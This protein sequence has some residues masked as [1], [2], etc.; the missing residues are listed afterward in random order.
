MPSNRPLL[1]AAALLTLLL[2]FP[3]T[4][5]A[6]NLYGTF[7][8]IK[9]TD[10]VVLDYGAG[11]YD[12]RLYG[13]DAPESGAP[14]ALEA[15]FLLRNLALGKEGK[16]RFYYRNQEDQMVAKAWVDGED[17]GLALVRAGYA[18]RQ[19]N[20]HYKVPEKG[21][22]DALEAAEKEAWSAGRGLWAQN[23][24]EQAELTQDTVDA[25]VP[26][27][28]KITGTT[29]VNTSQKGGG[30]NECAI[31]KDPSNP[32]R[33]FVS[34]NTS[35]AGLFAARSTDGGI[36]W[37]YPDPVDKTIADGDTGQGLSACCDPTITWDAFGNLYLTYLGGS[38]VAT[39][40][41]IDGGSTF[42]TLANF[43]S[44]ADQ[45]TVVAATTT[46]GVAVWVV[47]NQSGSMVA[48]GAAVSGLGAV[49]AFGALQAIPTTSGCSFG[50][51][52]IA[53]GGAVVQ[54]CQN[55]T[56]GQGPATIRINT[57]PDGL[58][59]MGFGASV[60]ATTTNVGGFDFIPAQNSRSVD[61]EAGLA[62]DFNPGSP[63]FG[64]LYLV[65]TEETVNENHDM[66]ILVR[67][68]DNNGATWSAP[69]QVNDDATTRSQ[70]LPKIAA[71]PIWG[72]VAICW[73]DC[74]DSG[75]NTAMKLFCSG[76]RSQDSATAFVTNVQVSDGASTSN[77][78][79]VE[80][81]DYMGL[82]FG[83]G[84][85]HPTWADTS[86]STADNPNGTA[87]FDGYVD[88]GKLPV[89]FADSFESSDTSAW[90]GVVP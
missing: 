90:S 30:D 61:S 35:S 44:S 85:A 60:T 2:A 86:N 47:W 80:F 39:L 70:F 4:A 76:K 26:P 8:E 71:D 57:D 79:G 36:T 11:T 58:G 41:S 17:L 55:P 83:H 37:G 27:E 40:L 9:G 34:C 75:T 16:I 88:R 22:T 68:S 20:V 73:H 46:A 10:V 59:P 69:V 67:T 82:I 7:V 25:L 64:R 63:T 74:R 62:F 77:G 54:A 5:E 66:Q 53:P 15:S 23:G 28:P 65:Y 45:P 12:V 78:S 48:R 38:G 81:G 87:N 89:I 6:K 49:A 42:T 24:S 51:I 1:L 31:A 14:F 43:S 50:D 13:I 32:N 84:T 33:L 18:R 52:A 29:D 21:Q 72:D 56:G 3:P 19:A